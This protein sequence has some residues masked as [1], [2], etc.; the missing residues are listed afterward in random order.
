MKKELCA[1]LAAVLALA[2]L[3]GCVH[4]PEDGSGPTNETTPVNETNETDGEENE[5]RELEVKEEPDE[6]RARGLRDLGLEFY[7][8][9]TVISETT[10][11]N[12]AGGRSEVHEIDAEIV[13]L[14]SHYTG[15]YK[16]TVDGEVVEEIKYEVNADDDS[17][18]IQRKHP[19][20][21]GYDEVKIENF[22]QEQGETFDVELGDQTRWTY[23]DFSDGLVELAGSDIAS[24]RF[25][26]TSGTL[27][28]RN[29]SFRNYEV[30]LDPSKD[31]VVGYLNESFLS[32]T[33]FNPVEV[34]PNEVERI[35]ASFSFDVHIH[36]ENETQFGPAEVNITAET[37]NLS[38]SSSSKYKYSPLRR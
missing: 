12:T 31:T 11:R 2:L 16:R 24:V 1:V 9:W 8:S 18:E 27:L 10:V 15:T 29:L 37:D 19:S 21:E 26:G 35:D 36:N 22:T 20:G 3:A 5:T 32:P 4:A 14:S 17:L 30:D 28:D 38:I 7:N 6:E 33:G 25:D 23:E 34:S 13:Q